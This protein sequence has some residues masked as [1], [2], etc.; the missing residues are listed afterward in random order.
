TA[1]KGA[2][3]YGLAA[4]KGIGL[5]SVNAIT[6]AREQ[7]PFKSLFDFCERLD[8]GGINKRVLEGLVCSGAFDTL[9]PPDAA[10]NHWRARLYAAI[11]TALARASRSRRTKAMGQDDLFGGHEMPE[12]DTASLPDTPAWTAM[13]MLAAEKKALGFYITGHPLDD[14]QETI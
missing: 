9:K 8:E 5:T 7:G 10:A 2:I 11:D 6:K 3:R 1:L 4:I 12:S 14:H 13:E